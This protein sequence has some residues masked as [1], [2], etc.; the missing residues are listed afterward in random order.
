MRV[1]HYAAIS[2]RELDM[3]KTVAL[4]HML[5]TQAFVEPYVWQSAGRETMLMGNLPTYLTR[6]T[7]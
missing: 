5:K 6:D 1:M 2:I 3:S 7:S 4:R